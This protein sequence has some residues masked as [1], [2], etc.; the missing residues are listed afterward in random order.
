M[1]EIL[2]PTAVKAVPALKR[3]MHRVEEWAKPGIAVVVLK[4]QPDDREAVQTLVYAIANKSINAEY[5]A[6][7]LAGNVSAKVAK[8]AIEEALAEGDLLEDQEESLNE[9]IK[10]IDKHKELF[11]RSRKL[12]F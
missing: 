8:A 9:A 4:I 7:S 5:A 12:P 6:N 10:K 3:Q 1:L 11:G 2:G